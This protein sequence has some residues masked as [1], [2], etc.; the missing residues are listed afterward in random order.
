MLIIDRTMPKTCSECFCH[1]A[2]YNVCQASR[3]NNLTSEDMEHRPDWC[4]LKEVIR[5][6]DCLYWD[7][8]ADIKA[9][10]VRAVGTCEIHAG[11][12]MTIS[13]GY[14]MW[15]V[16]KDDDANGKGGGSQ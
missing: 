14:C 5:C 3:H 4:P 10:G 6:K 16:L 15:A 9:N 13:E 12:M 7:K 2:E 11:W 1:D 8:V